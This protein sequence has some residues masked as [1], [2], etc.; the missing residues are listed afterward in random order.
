MSSKNRIQYTSYWNHFTLGAVYRKLHTGHEEPLAEL[1]RGFSD[2]SP[3]D[4]KE[5][6]R[7][8]RHEMFGVLEHWEPAKG[9]NLTKF[10]CDARDQKG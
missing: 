2:L 6:E 7:K 3:E 9:I 5:W 4:G 1:I 10:R 8:A